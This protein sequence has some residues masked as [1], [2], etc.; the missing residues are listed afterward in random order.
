MTA[1]SFARARAATWMSFWPFPGGFNVANVSTGVSVVVI[2]AA[3]PLPIYLATVG[4]SGFD[5]PVAQAGVVLAFLTAGVATIGLCLAYRQ[6]LA[7]GWS[8]PALIYLAAASHRYPLNELAGACLVTAAIVTVLALTGL[9]DRLAKWIPMPVI[10]GV[11]AGSAL[12]YCIGA[13][14]ALEGAPL[15]AGVPIIA[16]FV[17]KGL[18]SRWLPP[19]VAALLAGLPVALFASSTAVS[20]SLPAPDFV[21]LMPSFRLESLAALVPLLVTAVVVGNIQGFTV[22]QMNGFTPARNAATLVIG[23]TSF[24]HALFAAPPT[25]MQRAALAVLAGDEAGPHEAR[26][27]AAIVASIGAIMLGIFATSVA[28]VVLMLPPALMVALMGLV[29]M[30]TVIEALQRSIGSEA[31]SAAFVA[32]A[33]AASGATIAGLDGALWALIGGIVIQHTLERPRNAQD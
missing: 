29:L 12:Q 19:V 32:F 22:L 7:I 28:A 11:L 6:P 33:V 31:P 2:Y 17:A 20:T 14:G 10:M 8:M 3:G 21:P 9:A 15:V 26:H 1:R 30:P 5:Q 27:N 16:Y 13:F 25:T 23:L 4:N 18:R 24:V